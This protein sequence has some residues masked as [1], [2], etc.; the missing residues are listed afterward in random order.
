MHS[1]ELPVAVIGAGPVGL[2]AAAHLVERGLEPIIFEKGPSVGAAVLDWGHVRVF[3]P[4]KYNID[5]AA[6]RLLEA[7]GWKAPAPEVF[8]SGKDI[9][10]RYL[11]PLSNVPQIATGLRLG[12]TVT[13]ITRKGLSRV[14]SKGRE[15]APLMIRYEKNGITQ[16]VLVRAIL[17]A[18]GTW[19]Q[20][21]PMG[22]NGLPVSGERNCGSLSYGI[23]DVTG[24]RRAVFL[25]KRTLVVGSGHS[26]INTVIVLISTEK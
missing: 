13:A 24:T 26:A 15:N 5:D 4:W 19:G 20:P 2:A 8:P 22:I 10:E 18:S 17:D 23:P 21:N 3:S 7:V 12:S 11:A 9:V 14:I 1:L 6:R 25:G 16:D